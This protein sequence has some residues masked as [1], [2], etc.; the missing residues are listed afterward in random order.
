MSFKAKW[1]TMEC[2]IPTE[3]IERYIDEQ[4]FTLPGV[5]EPREAFSVLLTGSRATDTLTPRSDVD[6]DVVCPRTVCDSVQCAALSEGRI[7][8]TAE[9]FYILPGDDWHRYFGKELGRPHFSLTPLE[10]VARQFA[11]YDDIPI[12]I[13]THAKVIHD[14]GA[15]FARVLETFTGYPRDV[16]VRKIKYHWLLA[17]Y[18]GIDVFPHHHTNENELL[19]AAMGLLNAANELLRFFFLVEGKPF[20]YTEKLT[21]FAPS[22]KL[23]GEFMPFLRRVVDLAV[24][25]EKTET[26]AWTRLH[27]AFRLLF[28]SEHSAECRRL[29]KA[30]AD[31]MLAAGVEPA[32]VEADYRNIN[33]LLTGK[34]GPMP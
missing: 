32:W 17:A 16:L 13:W 10:E 2:G 28:E 3:A 31:A 26:D 27:E 9:S 4:I 30:C 6:I 1:L 33:E 15:Q 24:G 19:P 18:W 8:T 5:A 22:T 29:E 11:E 12:W 14:P 20:P 23:G 34:L 25:R 21:R 7:K